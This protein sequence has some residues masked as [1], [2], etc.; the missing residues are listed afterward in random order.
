M[1]FESPNHTM[2]NQLPESVFV[3]PSAS[4]IGNV[5]MGDD[6]SIWPST[7]LRADLGEITLGKGVNIQDGSVLHTEYRKSLS[8]GDYTL[9]GHKTMLHGCN[10][11]R[12]C[13]IGIGTIILDGAEIGDGASI[14]AGCLIRGNVKIPPFSLVVSKN[15]DI[16]IYPNRAPVATVIAGSLEYIELAKYYESQ[17]TQTNRGKHQEFQP[18]SDLKEKAVQLAKDMFGQDFK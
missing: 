7:V 17:A 16:K 8:I 13:L 1:I 4:I 14:T 2:F 10:I 18:S 12:G 15:G 11:G 3:H 5:K 6:C 9:V